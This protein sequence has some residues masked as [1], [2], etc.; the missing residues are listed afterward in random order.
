MFDAGSCG[1]SA[2][3]LLCPNLD[4][5]L[6]PALVPWS[7]RINASA[8]STGDDAIPST[9]EHARVYSGD[10]RKARSTMERRG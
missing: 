2:G 7:F 5:R 1:L 6:Q 4:S 8:S 9:S 3:V 10:S